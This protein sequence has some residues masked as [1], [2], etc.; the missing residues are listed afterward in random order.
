[1]TVPSIIDVVRAWLRREGITL[2][3]TCAVYPL[4]GAKETEALKELVEL[5]IDAKE[6]SSGL[7]A[8][9][10][11][12]CWDEQVTTETR[13]DPKLIEQSRAG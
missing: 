5:V 8:S 1:M 4:E 10:K 11:A 6:T 2:H 3:D 7:I 12:Q 13:V 9:I